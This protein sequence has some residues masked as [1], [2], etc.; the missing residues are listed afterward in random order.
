[1]GPE[2]LSPHAKHGP[3]LGTGTSQG[4]VCLE[5]PPLPHP[6]HV[7]CL[8][9]SSAT[10][11]GRRQGRRRREPGSLNKRCSGPAAQICPGRPV[12][13]EGGGICPR[14]RGRVEGWALPNNVCPLGSMAVSPVLGLAALLCLSAPPASS[15]VQHRMR[16]R[17]LAGWWISL[18]HG[19]LGAPGA[20]EPVPDQGLLSTGPRGAAGT[21]RSGW[22][23]WER[24]GPGR[25]RLGTL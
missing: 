12:S 2:E 24:E 13:T 19:G 10:H 16:V 5:E 22:V 15:M 21:P 17:R 14:R 7:L 6:V 3:Q 25:R 20:A 8:L 18:V 23:S 1:M 4:E 11:P 9:P